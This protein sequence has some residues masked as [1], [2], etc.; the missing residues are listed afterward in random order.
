MV[1]SEVACMVASNQREHPCYVLYQINGISSVFGVG[2]C[3][4][5]HLEKENENEVHVT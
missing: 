5:E 1:L 3:K 2:P 4:L